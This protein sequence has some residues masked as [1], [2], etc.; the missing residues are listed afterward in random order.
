ME[1][2]L[3][4]LRTMRWSR[5]KTISLWKRSQSA[6]RRFCSCRATVSPRPQ[7]RFDGSSSGAVNVMLCTSCGRPPAPGSCLAAVAAAAER[8]GT[9]GG[10]CAF[11]STLGGARAFRADP[12]EEVGAAS[13]DKMGWMRARY[14]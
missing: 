7:N 13:D 12:G 8:G 3:T 11:V 1:F 10:D 14:L 4:C 5:R 2:D 6:S 9:G